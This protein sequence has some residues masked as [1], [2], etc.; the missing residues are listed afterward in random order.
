MLRVGFALLSDD[1]PFCGEV[2]PGGSGWGEEQS[3][4]RAQTRALCKSSHGSASVW[5]LWKF[6]A[7]DFVISSLSIVSTRP[8]WWIAR[9]LFLQSCFFNAPYTHSISW[10]QIYQCSIFYFYLS[11]STHSHQNTCGNACE[12]KPYHIVKYLYQSKLHKKSVCNVFSSHRW[13]HWKPLHV[14][15]I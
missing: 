10:A 13:S 15:V 12:N 8:L 9:K 1:R 3:V 7:I 14:T 2:E 4:P 6:I 5:Q 11:C